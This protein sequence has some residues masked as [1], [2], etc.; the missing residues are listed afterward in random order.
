[1]N[2]SFFSRKNRWHAWRP[3]YSKQQGYD[4]DLPRRSLP[5]GE[6]LSESLQRWLKAGGKPGEA[7]G[8]HL[9]IFVGK[10]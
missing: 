2:H 3:D 4:P 1:M 8:Y 9:E 10:A 7:A 6:D 5:E